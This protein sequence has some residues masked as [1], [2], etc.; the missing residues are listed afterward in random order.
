[1]QWSVRIL[2]NPVIV[3]LLIYGVNPIDLEYVL[4]KVEKLPLV[5]GKVLEKTWLDEWNKKSSY[6][7]ELAKEAESKK[8]IVTAREMYALASKCDYASYLISSDDIESKRTVYK[9][10]ETSYRK[11]TEY[12]DNEVEYT[13]IPFRDAKVIP[14]YIHYPDKNKFKAPYPVAIIFAGMG[15]CKEELNTLTLPLV[16]RGVAVVSCDQPGTGA[17]LFD[18]DIKLKANEIELAFEKTMDAVSANNKLNENK[19]CSYGLCMGG[20]YAYRFCVKDERVKCCVNLFPL[21]IG[22]ISPDKL[23]R[24]MKSGKWALFQTGEIEKEEDYYAEMSVL[25]EGSFNCDYLLVHGMYDNWMAP[26]ACEH[27]FDK[28][29][30][31]KEKIVAEQPPVFSTGEAITH[32]MPVGEQLH[33]LKHTVSDWIAEHLDRKDD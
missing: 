31:L 23:P 25:E 7:F 16:E 8:N 21:F 26:E 3:R 15:S 9:Q 10:L 4:T 11:Q 20:G 2:L 22:K 28:A 14:A 13:E 5:N 19:V 30:G 12:F 33:W 1:M 6:Y 17:A 24:W 27:M 32:T 18:Y 29:S